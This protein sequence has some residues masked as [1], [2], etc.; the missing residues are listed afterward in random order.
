ME[1][2]NFLQIFPHKSLSKFFNNCSLNL[3]NVPNKCFPPTS[4]TL[5]L[6]VTL[7]T[8]VH[9]WAYCLPR[10]PCHIRSIYNKQSL[11]WSIFS[12]N[13][14]IFVFQ[15]SAI[16]VDTAKPKQTVLWLCPPP[17]PFTV[18][19]SQPF[20]RATIACDFPLQSIFYNGTW[21]SIWFN[22]K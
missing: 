12:Q 11:L 21:E 10:L 22:S 13:T 6:L 17:L 2:K 14:W 16:P 7:I 9:K 8:L 18:S 4:P 1:F 15:Y 3:S 19:R 20:G 5:I